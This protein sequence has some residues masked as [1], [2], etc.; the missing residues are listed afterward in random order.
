MFVTITFAKVFHS[1]E[2]LDILKNIPDMTWTPAIPDEFDVVLQSNNRATQDSPSRTANKVRYV[3][4]TPA[5]FSWLHS[6]QTCM[7]VKNQVACGSSWAFSAVGSLSDN[8]CINGNKQKIEYSEQFQISCDTANNGCNAESNYMEKSMWFL[9]N[10]GVPTEQC[11]SYK[12]GSN[13]L[14]GKCPFQCDDGTKLA[15]V[16]S[17]SYE[18]VCLGE[19]SI[20]NA[21]KFG[22]LQASVTVYT[23]LAFYKSGIYQHKYGKVEGHQFLVIVG[24]GS[25][26]GVNYW[27]VRNSWGTSWGEN[28]YLRILR[29]QNECGI[30]QECYL[31]K[32]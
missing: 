4:P 1:Q 21:L 23:D 5:E 10:V 22:T 6:E 7:T 2:V 19:E 14:R 16:K 9:K 28:G 18:N 20:M 8:L 25:E 11:V 17:K 31:Q 26:D 12:S 27:I 24:Y 15:L 3:G 32:V 13:S 29:G 30:E